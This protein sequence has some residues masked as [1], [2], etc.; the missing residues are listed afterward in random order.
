[1]CDQMTKISHTF[2]ALKLTLKVSADLS[3][4]TIFFI[5]CFLEMDVMAGIL[6]TNLGR[7]DQKHSL[8]MMAQCTRE[9]QNF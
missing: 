9:R 8:E 4:L 7:K 6:A 2:D 3:F 5:L 1:M